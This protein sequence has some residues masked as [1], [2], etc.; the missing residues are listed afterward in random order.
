MF[1]C[2]DNQ[3]NMRIGIAIQRAKKFFLG[4]VNTVRRLMLAYAL[5][6]LEEGYVW[7]M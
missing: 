7:V 5:N 2:I 1:T 4:E 6:N 3:A